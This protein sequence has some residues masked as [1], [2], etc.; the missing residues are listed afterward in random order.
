MINFICSFGLAWLFLLFLPVGYIIFTF[1]LYIVYKITGGKLNMI[2][3][4]KRMK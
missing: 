2:E 3:Y 4:F 1:F